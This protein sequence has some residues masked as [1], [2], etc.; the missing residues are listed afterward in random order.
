MPLWA[1][2]VLT[3]THQFFLVCTPC[4]A[5]VL[6]PQ[7]GRNLR[8][9]G[10]SASN[11]IGTGSSA[12]TLRNFL[13]ISPDTPFMEGLLGT[14]ASM[15]STGGSSG[16]S[17][18]RM[19]AAAA[20]AA[21]GSSG[22]SILT[23]VGSMP[24]PMHTSSS[25]SQGPSNGSDGRWG[26]TPSTQSSTM[27]RLSID[28]HI[29]AIGTASSTAGTESSS[30]GPLHTGGTLATSSGAGTGGRSSGGAGSSG[31]RPTVAERYAGIT[32]LLK[33]RSDIAVLRELKI[34]PLLGR[35]SYGR[36]YRGGFCLGTWSA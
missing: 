1:L 7:Q 25:Q 15:H 23:P 31:G 17:M 2:G 14:R 13:A 10:G 19:R 32:S 36:V 8:A 16:S 3:A 34:G 9:S 12:S 26:H 29:A 22:A 28:T 6:I 33:A 11:S 24:L 27:Q 5:L 18:Q 30:M 35:G 20:A 4:V 21:A